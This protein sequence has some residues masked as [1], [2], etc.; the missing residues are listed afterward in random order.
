[1]NLQHKDW[2]YIINDD[3]ESAEVLLNAGHFMTSVYHSHQCVEKTM[4]VALLVQNIEIPF[5][6]DLR[7][8]YKIMIKHQLKVEALMHD[9]GRINNYL[10]KLR[11]PY[12]DRL[13]KE[14]ALAAL[15]IAKTMTNLLLPKEGL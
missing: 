14:D 12:G 8:L 10:P 5:T 15:Q 2:L 11:Y 1:M 13:D 4:K 6:H 7:Q 9:I 3:I